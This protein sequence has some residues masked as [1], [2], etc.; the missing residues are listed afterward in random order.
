MATEV[1]G[2]G[3]REVV[4]QIVQGH[5]RRSLSGIGR[6]HRGYLDGVTWRDLPSIRLFLDALLSVNRR[7]SRGTLGVELQE[8]V[9]GTGGR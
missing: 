4:R 2:A 6:H 3:V 1:A 7:G 5:P 8:A 9:E